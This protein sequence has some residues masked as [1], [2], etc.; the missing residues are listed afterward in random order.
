MEARTVMQGSTTNSSIA[1]VPADS[2]AKT[3]GW[4]GRNW[5]RLFLALIALAVLGASGGYSYKFGP[6]LF[7]QPYRQAI[8]EL[9]QSPDVEKM[10][11]E[12]IKDGWFPAGS[13]NNEEGEARFYMN[14][15]GPKTADGREP[16][17]VVSVQARLVA[18]EWGFTQF[19]VRPEEGRP[20]NLLTEI[21]RE[22]PPDVAPFNPNSVPPPLPKTD[23]KPPPD[24]NIQLPDMPPEPNGK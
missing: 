19:D 1:G 22:R 4:W 5:K 21:M 17:A 24:V 6:I 15:H 3:R 8:A 2:S 7:S 16:K 14:V 10:L 20:L 23:A 12:P 11:G 18:G 9:R 13:V